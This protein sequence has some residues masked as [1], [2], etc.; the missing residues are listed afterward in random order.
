MGLGT[1][2]TAERDCTWGED[3]TWEKPFGLAT[4]TCPG[5]I[6]DFSGACPPQGHGVQLTA[7]L[8]ALLCYSSPGLPTSSNKKPYPGAQTPLGMVHQN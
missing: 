6:D 3:L 7:P 4:G 1:W 8:Q 2:E 5:A